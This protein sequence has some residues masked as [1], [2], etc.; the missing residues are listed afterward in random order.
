M[1]EPQPTLVDDAA[2]LR[3]LADRLD[4]NMPW[5]TEQTSGEDHEMLRRVAA[6]LERIAGSSDRPAPAAG[7]DEEGGG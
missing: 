1:S 6:H 2:Q 4:P 7:P 3:R 5:P